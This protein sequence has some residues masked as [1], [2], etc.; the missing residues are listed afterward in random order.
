MKKNC[1]IKSLL[2]GIAGGFIFALIQT[3]TNGADF[4]QALTA[5]ETL[6]TGL[7]VAAGCFIGYRMREKKK[8]QR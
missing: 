1:L 7:A 8:G 6:I 5:P 2:N 3:L 4:L